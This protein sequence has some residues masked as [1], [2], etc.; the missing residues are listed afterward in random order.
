MILLGIFVVVV[1]VR[2]NSVPHPCYGFFVYWT[3]PQFLTF[4]SK[5]NEINAV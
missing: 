5:A 2:L 3:L 1:V 4:M